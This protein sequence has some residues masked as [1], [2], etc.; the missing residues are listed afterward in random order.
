MLSSETSGGTSPTPT[1]T[2]A[3]VTAA[4]A[5]GFVGLASVVPAVVGLAGITRVKETKKNG[6]KPLSQDQNGNANGNGGA[7]GANGDLHA[8][9]EGEEDEKELYEDKDGVATPESQANYSARWQIASL[10]VLGVAGTALALAGSVLTL[11][12]GEEG[13]V[14]RW[15][16]FG[17]WALLLPQI[18]AIATERS[19]T[20]RYD[21]GLVCG[22][23]FVILLISLIVTFFRDIY[24]S[25]DFS[26]RNILLLIEIAFSICAMFICV[27]IPRR[28]DVFHDGKLVDRQFS[29][30][31]LD[32]ATFGW[33]SHVLKLATSGKQFEFADLPGMDHSTRS[34]ELY[35]SFSAL[36]K[37]GKIVKLILIAHW[38]PLAEQYFV[39]VID[40]LLIV[41]P[42]LAMFKLL[43][44]LEDRDHG[45]NVT[46]ETWLWVV[47]L[48][49]ALVLSEAVNNWLWWLGYGK[50]C[51]P[52]R[53]QLSALVFGKAMRRK[54][55]KGASSTTKENEKD[56]DTL[57]AVQDEE[58]EPIKTVEVDKNAVTAGGEVEED[59]QKTRQGVINLVGVDAN[60]IANFAV[61]NNLFFGSL[62]RLAVAFTFLCQ[63]IGWKALL[64]GVATQVIIFPTN[65]FFS[66][67]YSAATDELMVTRDKKL[68]V[69][70]EAL[71]GVRQIKFAALESSWQNKIRVIRESELSALLKMFRADTIL[72]FCWLLG[73]IILSAAS[74]GVFAVLNNGLP[75]S[76]AFTT[77]AILANIEMTLGF[78]PELTT[79]LL[80]AWVSINRI[81]EFLDSEERI[82]NT[83]PS[84][85]IGF[86]DVTLAWPSEGEREENAFMLNNLDLHFPNGELSVI[87]GP[88]GSGKSLL[89]AA[90]LGEVDVLKGRLL[91]PEAPPLEKRFDHKAN[92]SN[93]IIP[94]ALAFVSQQPW[95][96]NA[97]FKNNILFGLPFDQERY[98]K[99][100]SAC[101]LDKDLKIM[102]DGD[103]TEI[104]ANGI[105]LSGGQRW[106]ITLARAMYSRAGVL[107]LD[108]IFSAV[109]SHVGRQI[110]EEALTGEL[111]KDRTRVLVTHHVSLCLPRTK[112]SVRLGDGK[113]DFAGDVEQLGK[114][115]LD[116]LLKEEQNEN[117]EAV[118][119]EVTDL[120]APQQTIGDRRRSSVLKA[121]RMSQVS[122]KSALI[123]ES[124]LAV[125]SKNTT[126]KP[127]V[128]VEEEARD[129]GWVKWSVYGKYFKAS[130]GLPPW[131][132]ILVVFVG[133]QVAL[134]GRSWVLRVWTDVHSEAKVMIQQIH[135]L[136]S[137]AYAHTQGLNVDPSVK[138][139]L[140]L[141]LGIAGVLCILGTIRFWL[142][143]MTSIRASRKM[144]ENITY[145]VLRARLR[146]L[147]TVP[148]GRILN[149]MTADFNTIDSMM[150]M[151]I[152]SFLFNFLTLI[153]IIAAGILVSP[154]VIFLAV[155]LIAICVWYAI[156]YLSGAR[157]AKRM[158]SV[159]KS[160]IFELFS[161]ALAGVST[162]RAFQ[163]S[164]TYVTTM[165]ARIDE[166]ASATFATWI[167]NRWL[168]WRLSLIGSAFTVIVAILIVS[169]DGIDA[170]LG[171]FAIGFALQYTEA[172]TW[173]LRQFANVELGMNAAERVVEY[174]EIP[175]EDE[176]GM[177]APAAWPTEGKLEVHDLVVGYAEDLPPVLN[178]IS[179]NVKRHE[180]IGVVGRTGAGKS[181]LTLALFRFLEARSGSIHI[182]GLDI[183]K[184][185]LHDLRSRLAI[186]PQDP[187]LFSG[188]VRSNIDPFNQHPDQALRDALERVHLVKATTSTGPSSAAASASENDTTAGVANTNPFASLSSPISE[189]GSNLSQ[190]QRQLLCLARAI[191]ARPKI[192]VLDEATSAV[193]K[194]TDELIQRS[195][196]EE[197]GGS[198][199]V[200][201]AHR[202]STIA[203]FDRILVLGEGRVKEFGTPRELLEKEGDE[204]E[205]VFRGMVED[206]GEREVLREIILGV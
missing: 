59:L 86:E 109:D 15:L 46:K 92:K 123:D 7:V 205:A 184:V 58:D 88:T 95:I 168:S 57:K 108:D 23:S 87:S 135:P 83:I 126:Q 41:A 71:T 153:G 13:A 154:Y 75:P 19:P 30:S 9:D 48:A 47:V 44:L 42:Q 119:D 190:G 132:L 140:S 50:L 18:I 17:I 161:T 121:R 185:K 84:D 37:T 152:A 145:T 128:F 85:S 69:I 89:L 206:S 198:T 63:I 201:I 127:K 112:Y 170:A 160:P 189:A 183:S 130:G 149:R 192:M 136:V 25:E 52:I 24:V 193:D 142:V 40:G 39:T 178:G 5:I 156:Y 82:V 159:A 53:V 51:I 191:I 91:V 104:G 10:V 64:A 162:I 106:R 181:S 94:E 174:S 188:T 157:E 144:F 49:F 173:V 125:D 147:D 110:Y 55:F 115:E 35:D 165:F 139:Y 103:A 66:K 70:N 14:E 60:R 78:L 43:K 138:Y 151:A 155:L 167:F 133:Y 171:G 74:I 158:E 148:V 27:L 175:I 141:Y 111:S 202:L 28:P 76:V 81:G 65:I 129:K 107:L 131:L 169:V 11:T 163:K 134:V 54:D 116:A 164:D 4:V 68:A 61:V 26:P 186:I 90:I 113:V 195:I 166:Y 137:S 97:T 2:P 203:D 34:R 1:P 16:Q 179:F 79:Y 93:W 196:R 117:E 118:D 45:M 176:G 194:D 36:N 101:A 182:D 33:P 143:F 31:W 99:V 73:P 105:N 177:D 98:D 150:A 32:R 114:T 12:S 172:V 102:T 120:P 124:G 21:Q 8:E 200:V 204:A 187:V 67:M 29:N 199:L 62:C 180:R 6:Y 20:K 197:F 77:I 80:D 56:T 3:L 100:I 72:I 146:W 122:Q 38:R 22:S 96:E